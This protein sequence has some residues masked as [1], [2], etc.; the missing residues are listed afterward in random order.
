VMMATRC[1]LLIVRFLS[2]ADA[3]CNATP[4]SIDPVG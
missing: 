2:R 4:V 3:G 1:E